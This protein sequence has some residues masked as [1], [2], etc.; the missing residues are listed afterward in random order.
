MMRKSMV[1]SIFVGLVL[2]GLV[3]AFFVTFSGRRQHDP[4]DLSY[5]MRAGSDKTWSS[6]E[7]QSKPEAQFYLGLTLIRTNLLTMIDEVP[8]LSAVPIIGKRFFENIS[9]AIDNNIGQDQLAEAYQWIKKS[10]DAGFA[11]A[12]EAEKLFAG[13]VATSLNPLQRT[14]ASRSAQET[15]RT[16]PAAGSLR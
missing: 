15:N 16:P 10:A 4:K 3:V 8:R 5:W 7:A 2:A 6:E 14:R 9:Y 11:P 13:R 12:R 1:I